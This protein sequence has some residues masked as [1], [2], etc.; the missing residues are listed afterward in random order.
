MSGEDDKRDG[1]DENA[2]IDLRIEAGDWAAALGDPAA[3]VER[4][5]A[6]TARAAPA[7]AGSVDLL[8]TDDDRV[9]ALNASFRGK[10]GSTNVLS[11]PSGEPAPGFLGDIALAYET[12]AREAARDGKSIADHAAHLIVH[13]LLH[14]IGYDHLADEEATAMERLESDILARLG[15]TDPYALPNQATAPDEAGAKRAT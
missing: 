10:E 12:C 5:R 3:L 4:C 15:V 8:L 14:L 11:F 9:A 2:R 1:P 6:E 7:A 13:G